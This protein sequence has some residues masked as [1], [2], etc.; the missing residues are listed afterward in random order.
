M[1]V[2]KISCTHG[3]RQEAQQALGFV[4][5]V[6]RVAGTTHSDRNFNYTVPRRVVSLSVTHGAL[7]GKATTHIVFVGAYGAGANV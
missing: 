3:P 2:S 6:I 7:P 4:G 5:G 1:R